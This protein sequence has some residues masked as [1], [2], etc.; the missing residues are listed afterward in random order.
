MHPARASDLVLV[1]GKVYTA[2]ANK[3]AEAIAVTGDMI[4]RVGSTAEV[5]K[6]KAAGTKIV[7][8]K[9]MM[10]I[11]GIT[12]NHTH[13]WFGSLAL[14][15]LNLSTPQSNINDTNRELFIAKLKNYAASHKSQ[16][17][18]FAR[19]A[20][21][22][23]PS[24]PIAILDEAV[25][26][27]PLIVHHTGE[28]ALWVNSRTLALA[29]ITD[30]PLADPVEESYVERDA[31]GHPTGVLR[32]AAQEVIERALPKMPVDEQVRILKAGE[33]Y[34]NSYGVTSAVALTGGLEDLQA[35]EEL[36]KRGQLTLRIRQAFASM[37]VNQHLTPDFLARLETARKTWHDDWLSAN[38]V[39][40]FM[41][42]SSSPATGVLYKAED[43]NA[44]IKALDSRGFY[45]TSHAL[46]PEGVKMALDGYEL[47]KQANGVKDQCFR[48]EHGGQIAM[49]DVPRRA[50]LSVLMSTQPAFCCSATVP[51]NP[52][53]SLWDSGTPL[54]FSSDWPCSC[55]HR[56]W[57]GSNRRRN[58]G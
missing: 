16:P 46:T 25:P 7:D 33:E 17:L 1:N 42:G 5:L 47:I 51:S 14:T 58:A 39:K 10:V 52:W 37:A 18:L 3:W 29:G 21:T 28:H 15:N 13:I 6:T 9:G 24:P 43:Y 50:R 54:V 40:F 35:Y 41:D 30:N 31:A 23:R 2:A 4:E 49:E 45:L 38:I 57:R 8:L 22:K 26:D 19:A 36:R 53:K 27:K 11:P 48:I 44:I 32:E 55:P 20:F 56:R 12:D 34:L